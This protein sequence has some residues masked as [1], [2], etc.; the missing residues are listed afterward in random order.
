MGI[1]LLLTNDSVA[2][3]TPWLVV[4]QQLARVL[5]V[6]AATSILAAAST[7]LLNSEEIVVRGG[8]PDPNLFTN[9]S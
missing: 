7:S 3:R 1:S 6:C 9:A 5:I 8:R 4:R 2:A